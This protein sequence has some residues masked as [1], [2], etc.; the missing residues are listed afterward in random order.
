M[1]DLRIAFLVYVPQRRSRFSLARMIILGLLLPQ[2][3]PMP[4]IATNRPIILIEGE[5][6]SVGMWMQVA[7]SMPADFVWVVATYECV[8]DLNH[9]NELADQHNAIAIAESNRA[10]LEKAASTKFDREG[11]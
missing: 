7:N 9:P 1:V 11:G 6:W 4:L 3:K 2:S 8:E 10:L 5:R